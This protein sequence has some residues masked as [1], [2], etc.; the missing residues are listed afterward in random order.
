MDF[1]TLQKNAFLEKRT[2]YEKMI[3]HTFQSYLYDLPVSE[4]MT[5]IY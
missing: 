3:K 2:L 1:C 5:K 4:K